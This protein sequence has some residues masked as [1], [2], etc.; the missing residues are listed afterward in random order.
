MKIGGAGD[1]DWTHLGMSSQSQLWSK[2]T[3]SMIIP[4]NKDKR[5]WAPVDACGPGSKRET[6]TRASE[7]S[8]KSQE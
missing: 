8:R 1:K 7:V 6:S 3:Q 2:F 4:K 5:I